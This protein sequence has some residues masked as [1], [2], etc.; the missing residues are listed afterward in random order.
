MTNDILEITADGRCYRLDIDKK[1][2]FRDHDK[3]VRLTRQQWDLLSFFVQNPR[4]KLHTKNDLVANVW[5]KNAAVTDDAVSLGV[6]SLRR[7]LD[8]KG[9]DFIQT[10]HGQGYRFVADVNRVAHK[11]SQLTVSELWVPGDIEEFI[12]PFTHIQRKSKS[13]PCVSAVQFVDEM[14]GSYLTPMLEYAVIKNDHDLISAL[15]KRGANINT[16]DVS[17][18]SLG[19]LAVCECEQEEIDIVS[20]TLRRI[21]LCGYDPNVKCIHRTNI[22]F[23][24]VYMDYRAPLT[25]ISID[26]G[27]NVD[28]RDKGLATPLMTASRFL[29]CTNAKILLA[30]GADPNAID[31]NGNTPAIC[32][33]ENDCW[34]DPSPA[35]DIESQIVEFLGLL[36]LYGAL[37]DG[38]LVGTRD[39]IDVAMEYGYTSV[40]AF[41]S[42]QRRNKASF[43]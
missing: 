9:G 20:E 19:F 39:A 4:H 33:I 27:A 28:H 2:L 26:V 31:V 18:G 40:V 21:Y 15:V 11:E 17:Y 32:A 42:K 12:R 43:A 30:A 41:L 25:K 13:I 38:G 16:T 37:L 3:R 23:E 14:I 7:V 10:E 29:E 34:P 1:A 8:D 6:K 35:T 24:T 22:L 36:E 5:A